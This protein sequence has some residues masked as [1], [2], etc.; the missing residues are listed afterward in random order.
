MSKRGKMSLVSGDVPMAL[1][2]AFRQ[3][4]MG[5]SRFHLGSGFPLNL[6]FA[7]FDQVVLPEIVDLA[8]GA[9]TIDID[10]DLSI[11]FDQLERFHCGASQI[12]DYPSRPG[13]C[14]DQTK[15][16]IMAE[17]TL[18]VQPDW[19]HRNI[20]LEEDEDMW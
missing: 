5:G 19:V 3:P 4:K 2:I 16:K 10:T 13:E 6:P 9:D 11:H 8:E 1:M 12:Y 20:E 15:E 18:G 17:L 7:Y 14:K